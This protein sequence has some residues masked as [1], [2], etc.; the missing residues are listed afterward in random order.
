MTP[1]SWKVVFVCVCKK[2]V[3]AV[4]NW[5][6]IF[7]ALSHKMLATPGLGLQSCL[8]LPFRLSNR[9]FASWN[10]Y[11]V[12]SLEWQRATGRHLTYVVLAQ[13]LKVVTTDTLFVSAETSRGPLEA[14]ARLNII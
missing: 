8:S 3:V 11:S 13:N 2:R 12:V 14:E 5:N 6:V 1:S 9:N 4:L 10:L 7:V